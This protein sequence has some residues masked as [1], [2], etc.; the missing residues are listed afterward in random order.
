MASHHQTGHTGEMLARSYFEKKGYRVLHQNWRFHHLEVDLIAQHENTLHIIEVKCLQGNRGGYP[1]QTVSK[2]K[3]KN[4]MDAAA[5]YTEQYPDWE[6]VRIDVL[7]ITL[8][9]HTAPEYFLIEDVY[10]Y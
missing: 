9:K 2:K 10:D 3:I 5:A 1:E 8:Y 7:S 4:L 6:K